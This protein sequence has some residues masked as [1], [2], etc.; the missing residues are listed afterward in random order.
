MLAVLGYYRAIERGE[1]TPPCALVPGLPARFDRVVA[2][3]LAFEREERWATVGA[4]RE[5][6]DPTPAVS[7]TAA[8]EG[9]VTA[10]PA[11]R[12]P[13]HSTPGAMT[14]NPGADSLLDT[15]GPVPTTSSPVPP[16]TIPGADP[17]LLEASP[18]RQTAPQPPSGRSAA[19]IVA[20]LVVGCVVLAVAFRFATSGPADNEAPTA[21]AA[22]VASATPDASPPIAPPVVPTSVTVEGSSRPASPSPRPA[23][24]RPAAEPAALPLDRSQLAGS[25][26]YAWTWTK[27]GV[28][29]ADLESDTVEAGRI[30]R[31]EV[32]AVQAVA[33]D[34]RTSSA[35]QTDSVT[36]ANAT[37][38]VTSA[39]ISPN[40]L[41]VAT[42]AG[43]L[44]AATD[45]EGDTVTWDITW[46]VNGARAG[47]GA[48][49]SSAAYSRGDTVEMTATPSDGL[50]SGVSATDTLTVSNAAPTIRSVRSPR[51]RPRSSRTISCA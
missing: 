3:C 38:S 34:G 6:L 32:W 49:L 48:S 43:A 13:A 24:V 2:G 22:P 8:V 36:V 18:V 47:T 46:A 20:A 4:L 10:V 12:T 42:S 45:P 35:S 5:A 29:Q 25:P 19:G 26:Y 27:D 9:L 51:R 16:R 30:G 33:T 41:T 44:L 50:G 14:Y 15:E 11:A 1:Y 31:G 17:S 39:T 7:H 23:P 40:P 37:P 21:P 28:V